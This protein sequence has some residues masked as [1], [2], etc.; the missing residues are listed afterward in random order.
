MEGK[1]I[2]VALE[3]NGQP[4]GAVSAHFGRCPA[5]G[6]WHVENGTPVKKEMVTNPFYH[7]HTPGEV[8]GLIKTLGAHVIIAG[9]MGSRAISLFGQM[10]IEVVTGAVGNPD[11]VVAAYIRFLRVTRCFRG[12]RVFFMAALFRLCWMR[13]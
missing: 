4:E 8:P 10:G 9:G 13:P 1:Q 3:S 12:T 5:Y 2:A 7:Q 6:V 11:K